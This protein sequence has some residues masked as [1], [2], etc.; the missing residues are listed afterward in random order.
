LLCTG[1]R[2]SIPTLKGLEDVGFLTSDEF[3]MKVEE[4]PKNIVIVGG[5]YV[6]VELGFFM[7]MMGSRVTILGRNSRIVPDEEPEA[8]E[9]LRKELLKYINIRVNH[10]AVK[11][12]KKNGKKVVVSK[13]LEN[14]NYDEAEADEILIATGRRANSDLTKPE[15]TGVKVDNGGWIITNEYLETTKPN[16]WAFGDAN[17][18]FMF[19]HKANYEAK[20]VFYNA[21]L[22][23]H[24]KASYHAIPHAIFTYPE[25]AAVG[26][27][28]KEATEKFH[29]WIGYNLYEDTAKGD[30]M[31]LKDYFVKVIVEK[32]T[33]KILGAHIIG[34]NASIL[35][36]EIVNLM[37]T[38]DQALFRYLME[39]IFIQHS[40]RL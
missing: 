23:R 21:F 20:I 33:H 36:Q 19:K 37:Y 17:D 13:N 4:L 22:G 12:S 5:G 40:Q 6:A 38:K 24:I 16:I 39:Y 7:A 9:L 2:P 35:I 1:S 25:V 29:I 26:L 10:A 18:K 32:D 14:G 31:I 15:K 30:A 11:T 34:P 28:E 3:F 27:S 8:S